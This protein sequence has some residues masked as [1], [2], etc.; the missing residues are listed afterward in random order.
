MKARHGKRSPDADY[1]DGTHDPYK[2]AESFAEKICFFN[3]V[4]VNLKELHNHYNP[5]GTSSY[6]L[7]TD[8]LR[9]VRNLKICDE[10]DGIHSKPLKI[11]SPTSSIY[12]ERF[13]IL[14]LIHGYF[15]QGTNEVHYQAED[16]N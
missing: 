2:I 16:E 13:F 5:I 1:I 10:N 9:A 15:S 8:V 11:I 4:C 12:L 14:C 3:G 7:T 6:L